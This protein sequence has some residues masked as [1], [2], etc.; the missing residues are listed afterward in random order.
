[1]NI[2]LLQKAIDFY[3]N[4]NS[5]AKTAKIF[6]STP[7][8]LKKLFNE[9]NIYI[10]N[11]KE[12]LILE[13]I[14]RTKAINH[15]Y[16]SVL[17]NENS[18]YIGFLAADG[19]IRKDRNEIKIGLSS[20]DKEFLQ[21]FKEKIKTEKE[22][23]TYMTSNGFECSELS[24]SSLQ[25][26]LDLMN[27]GIVPN[28]TVIGLNL[29]LIPKQYQLAFI[30]GFFD[31]DGS[32]VFNKNTKQIKV[33]FVSHTKEILEQI[34]NFFNKQGYIYQDNRKILYSL[35]FSTLPSLK[36]LK[37]FYKLN[38]PCLKRKYEKYQEILIL[39]K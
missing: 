20:V 3:N 1:M 29:N 15:N 33:S 38:T 18:Y 27:Y 10:R 37:N 30:K 11:Q 35:E 22:I 25:M 13:N 8:T 34:N 31:G 28:K 6:H 39:R 7:N 14:K 4:G 16:F 12:Q 21:D 9:K 32:V 23:H 24:F 2:E 17:N 5:M 19:T 26:K 36:I